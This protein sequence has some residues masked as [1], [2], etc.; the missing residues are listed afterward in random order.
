MSINVDFFF[1][2]S[3]S[4]LKQMDVSDEKFTNFINEFGIAGIPSI[5]GPPTWRFLHFWSM[6]YPIAPTAAQK[7][8][9]ADFIEEV[10]KKLGCLGCTFHA[11]EYA[12]KN[13]VNLESRI[14]LVQWFVEFHNSVNEKLRKP[15]FTEKQFFEEYIL[16][17]AKSLHAPKF[18]KH[19]KI[20]IAFLVLTFVLLIFLLIRWFMLNQQP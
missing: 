15:K 7:Q 5:F 13:P 2:T 19:D 6:R 8:D 16:K 11:F 20:G 17:P 12:D 3:L 10:F 18:S 4:V 1:C 14:G 9:A